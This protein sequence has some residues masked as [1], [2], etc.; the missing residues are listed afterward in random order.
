MRNARG[1]RDTVGKNCGIAGFGEPSA[2]IA[3]SCSTILSDLR[4]EERRLENSGF[5]ED[6]RQIR[7][8]AKGRF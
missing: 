7:A 5:A 3:E 8:N 1:S 2:R 6:D 4:S